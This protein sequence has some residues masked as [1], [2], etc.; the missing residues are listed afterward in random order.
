M[1]DKNH[2]ARACLSTF[3]FKPGEG[4]ALGMAVIEDVL[5]AYVNF[6]ERHP[7][8][9][10]T[11]RMP[12]DAQKLQLLQATLEALVDYVGRGADGERSGA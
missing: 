7:H 4:I 10:R 2:E 1:A 8:L 5:Q 6:E 12:F 3:T 9:E 11:V